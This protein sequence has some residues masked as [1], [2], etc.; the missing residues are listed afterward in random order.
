M[1]YPYMT[2]WN[3]HPVL[4]HFTKKDLDADIRYAI[5]KNFRLLEGPWKDVL[6]WIADDKAEHGWSPRPTGLPNTDN[7]FWARLTEFLNTKT[8]TFEPHRFA[9]EDLESVDGISIAQEEA[10][11]FLYTLP[12]EPKTEPKPEPKRVHPSKRPPKRA[13]NKPNPGA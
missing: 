7:P 9:K 12:P 3:G 13:P 6:T 8:F 10:L 2:L 4:E 1:E 5:K 11:E